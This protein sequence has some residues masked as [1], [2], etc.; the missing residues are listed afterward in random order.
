MAELKLLWTP[1]PAEFPA[2]D[3]SALILSQEHETH[4]QARITARRKDQESPNPK[5]LTWEAPEGLPP[6]ITITVSSTEAAL[7]IFVADWVGLFDIE[8]NY[9]KDGSG[10]GEGIGIGQTPH[11]VDEWENVPQTTADVYAY[12]PSQKNVYRLPLVVTAYTKADASGNEIESVTYTITVYANYDI[13]KNALK[14]ALQA[15]NDATG[16]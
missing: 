16:A 5:S 8:I 11:A 9:M 12:Y 13:G 10:P 7:A 3:E 2:P 6:H 15:R 1:E 4:L 14:Q